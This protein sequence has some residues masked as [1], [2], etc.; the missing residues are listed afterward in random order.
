MHERISQGEIEPVYCN[1]DCQHRNA[2]R[3]RS[4]KLSADGQEISGENASLVEARWLRR[5][6]AIIHAPE[7]KLLDRP[8][9]T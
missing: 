8:S 5:C 2:M 4:A 1:N 7:D 6:E 3:Y 9:K